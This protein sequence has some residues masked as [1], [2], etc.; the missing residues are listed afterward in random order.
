MSPF[1]AI[2]GILRDLDLVLAAGI[3]F[4]SLLYATFLIS[5]WIRSRIRKGVDIRLG[6]ALF[7]IGLAFNS[8]FFVIAD[9]YTDTY[10]AYL[11]WIRFGYIS[12]DLSLVGFFFAME[13]ILPYNTRNSITVLGLVIAITTVFFSQ[14]IMRLFAYAIGILAFIM[15]F[16][17]YQYFRKNVTGETLPGVRLIFIGILIGF[18]GFILRTDP[19]YDFFGEVP[20]I[21]GPLLL[22]IGIGLFGASILVSPAFDELDWAEQLV[23]LYVIGEGGI[24]M[25]HHRFLEVSAVD[26]NLAAA[27]LSGVQD[28]LREI[29]SAEGGFNIVSIGEY[30]I[31]FSHGGHVSSALVSKTSY[32]ILLGKIEDFTEKFELLFQDIIKEHSRSVENDER[33]STLV[34]SVFSP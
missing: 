6:W 23:G 11:Y 20:Y 10:E 30:E 28:L 4:Y 1:N 21:L 27:G 14:E 17:F 33:A 34:K 29:T 25:Y 8:I 12:V 2:T 7:L 24:L 5:S 19:I 16:S 31:L 26:E 18:I 22:V 13:H 15:L 9:V 32:Q 3:A